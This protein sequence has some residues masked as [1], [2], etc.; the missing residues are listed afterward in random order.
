MVV[1]GLIYQ[2]ERA[3]WTGRTG[4]KISVAL[5][6]LAALLLVGLAVTRRTPAGTAAA[7]AAVGAVA[8]ASHFA[9]NSST[10]TF[11]GSTTAPNNRS[12]YHAALDQAAFVK[13]STAQDNSLPVFWYPAAKHPEFASIQSMYYFG[14]TYLDLE[15]PKVTS[16]MSQR[17]DQSKPQ[18][19][20]M[21]CETRDC[22]GGQAALRRAGHSYL[23][24]SA[25]RISQGQIRLWS[26]LLR[27]APDE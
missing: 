6:S 20:V 15:L 4:M 25:E 13:R 18:T 21:L 27:R 1:L 8:V 14:Y 3:D 9:I 19:I 16:G 24:D 2:N 17:L 22:A 10:G 11:I 23:E 12:L 7:V 26:V 5:M